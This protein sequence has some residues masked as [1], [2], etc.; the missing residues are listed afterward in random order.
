ME[1]VEISKKCR[2]NR[3]IAISNEELRFSLIFS[4]KSYFF[5]TISSLCLMSNIQCWSSQKKKKLKISFHM[6][7]IHWKWIYMN[8]KAF[9]LKNCE[10][11]H[12]R[13]K[14]SS[15]FHRKHWIS[16][17]NAEFQNFMRFQTFHFQMQNA[18][19][20]WTNL[21]HFSSIQLNSRLLSKQIFL[22]PFFYCSITWSPYE[23]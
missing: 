12:L 9:I 21:F 22:R 10:Q 8:Q 17:K 16:V 7:M 20:F 13:F 14:N 19:I 4:A 2:K 15:E 5:C 1:Q 11:F 6:P 18:V 23:I 3:L